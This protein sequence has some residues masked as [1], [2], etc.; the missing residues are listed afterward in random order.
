METEDTRQAIEN[1]LQGQESPPA[2]LQAL[3][4]WTDDKI[5][6]TTSTWLW[7]TVTPPAE[8]DTKSGLYMP[9]Q[10]TVVVDPAL[11][12]PYNWLVNNRK[13]LQCHHTQLLRLHYSKYNIEVTLRLK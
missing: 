2:S 7:E 5:D 3:S 1:Y 9:S 6:E 4:R 13:L 11:G 8:S 12:E 10:E